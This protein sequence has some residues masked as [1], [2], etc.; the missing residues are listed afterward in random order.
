MK[1]LSYKLFQ[2]DKPILTNR[3]KSLLGFND[4]WFI[5]I[6]IPGMSMIMTLMMYGGDFC[7]T[8]G[9]TSCIKIRKG[10]LVS[11]LY[12]TTFWFLFRTF[13]LT[14]RRFFAK[15][16]DIIPRL[17]IQSAGIILLLMGLKSIFS[18]TIKP[19]LIDY[20]EITSPPDITITLASFITAIMI[21]GIYESI[22]FYAQ[23]QESLLARQ[24]LEK[25]N[26]QTQL[27]GLKNQVNPHFLFNSLNT[28]SYLIPEDPHKAENF[29]QQLSKVYRYILEIRDRKLISLEE[30]LKFTGAYIYL[31]KERFEDSLRVEINIPQ[32]HLGLQIVPLSLQILLENA[33]KHN[34]VS[35]QNPLFVTIQ[36]DGD[37]QIMV[38]NN[39]QKKLK[40]V[41]GTKTGLQNIRNRYSFFS[42]KTVK[43]LESATAFKVTL[44]LLKVETGN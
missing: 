16:M 14:F 8:E 10:F 20:L 29:V 27:D 4:R 34:V 28:L 43:V 42:G 26:I 31:L 13:I 41:P 37:Q 12:T 40:A 36:L 18:L 7:S 24:K 38:E 17:V 9:G 5:L 3:T 22:Y 33:I 23:L 1:I 2:S 30:E 44:P 6:G 21:F 35:K 19:H 11:L 25:A 39:L 32:E 15:E